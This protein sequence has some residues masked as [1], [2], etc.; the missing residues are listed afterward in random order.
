[1]GVSCIDQWEGELGCGSIG[2]AV[3]MASTGYLPDYFHVHTCHN[4]D[5]LFYKTK[6]SFLTTLKVEVKKTINS[7]LWQRPKKGCR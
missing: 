1:M 3:G 2:L 6:K 7:P 5:M 4:T